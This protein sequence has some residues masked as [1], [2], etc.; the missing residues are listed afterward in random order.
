MTMSYEL[1]D[2]ILILHKYFIG[3]F[4]PVVAMETATRVSTL[5]FGTYL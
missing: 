1:W 3:Q 4:Y 2:T 5:L